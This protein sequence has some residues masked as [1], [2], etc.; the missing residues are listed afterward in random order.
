MAWMDQT[1]LEKRQRL[2]SVHTEP[3]AKLTQ[4]DHMIRLSTNII[5]LLYFIVCSIRTHCGS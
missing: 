1:N 2:S 5:Q 3:A 4:H